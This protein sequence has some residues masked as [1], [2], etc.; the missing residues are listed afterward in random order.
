MKVKEAVIPSLNVEDSL[1]SKTSDCI[2]L[3]KHVE[4]RNVFVIEDHEVA[5][6]VDRRKVSHEVE[7]VDGEVRHDDVGVDLFADEVPDGHTLLKVLVNLLWLCEEVE[8]VHATELLE[9]WIVPVCH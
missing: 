2:L 9:D 8:V 3:K 4:W 1:L 6:F 5:P 7:E